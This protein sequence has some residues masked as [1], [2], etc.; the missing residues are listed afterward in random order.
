MILAETRLV[1]WKIK[2]NKY[3]KSQKKSR[4]MPTIRENEEEKRIGGKVI[5]EQ[6]IN[7]NFSGKYLSLQTEKTP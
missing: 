5:I 3:F 2:L 7:A 1:A 4:E 6:I